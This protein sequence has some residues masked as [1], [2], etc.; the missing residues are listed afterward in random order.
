MVPGKYRDI[1]RHRGI[2]GIYIA[3]YVC[4]Y[5]YIYIQKTERERERERERDTQTEGCMED[6]WEILAD[7]MD[8]TGLL[9]EMGLGT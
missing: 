4:I 8:S 6:M 3:V 5:I 9:R 1:C 7:D 2:Y